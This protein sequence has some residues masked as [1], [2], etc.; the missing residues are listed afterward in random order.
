M[1]DTEPVYIKEENECTRFKVECDSEN[2]NTCWEKQNENPNV[3]NHEEESKLAVGMLQLENSPKTLQDVKHEN[4]YLS[5]RKDSDGYELASDMTKSCDVLLNNQ[6][7]NHANGK[8]ANFSCEICY[9]SFHSQSTLDTHIHSHTDYRPFQCNICSKRFMQ[10]RYLNTH[11]RSHTEQFACSNCNKCFSNKND[12][13]RHMRT[14]TGDRP[15]QCDVCKKSFCNNGDLK[16]HIR[17]HTGERPYTCEV[18]NKSFTQRNSL[19]THS[20]YHEG[21]RPFSCDLCK[22]S[23]YQKYNLHRHMRTHTDTMLSLNQESHD[24]NAS[25]FLVSD[26]CALNEQNP[27]C[28]RVRPFSCDVCSKSFSRKAD[29]ERHMRIHTGDRPFT[30]DICWKTFSQ[31]SSHHRHMRCHTGEKPFSCQYCDKSFIQKYNLNIHMRTH[32]NDD[33]KSNT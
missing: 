1:D 17:I 33:L 25:A 20:R 10:R 3:V 23:F 30:C 22:K 15:F 12:L 32:V 24:K 14:H 4:T 5:N 29:L 28:G 6:E 16:K 19:T 7:S 27:N 13:E 21:I 2:E 18:C 8:I 26:H 9:E 11:M 31:L